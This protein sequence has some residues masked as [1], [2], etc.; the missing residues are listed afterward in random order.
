[1]SEGAKALQGLAASVGRVGEM[2][3]D[4]WNGSPTD[5]PHTLFR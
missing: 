2:G 4:G 1:M 5:H 3:R